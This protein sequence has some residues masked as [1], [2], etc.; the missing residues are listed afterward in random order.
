MNRSPK[1]VFSHDRTASVARSFCLSRVA[2]EFML[3]PDAS[4][5]PSRL[6]PA[7]GTGAFYDTKF[8]ARQYFDRVREH[9]PVAPTES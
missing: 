9:R 7:I 1:K 5:A 3:R 8:Y 2:R 6:W 4:F